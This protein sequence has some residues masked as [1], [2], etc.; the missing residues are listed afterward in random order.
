[1]KPDNSNLTHRAISG[2]VWVATG[3][4]ATGLLRLLVL[5]LLT[6]LLSPADF[7][8]VGAALIVI[9]FS[10]TFSQ[11]GLG[12]ALVQRPRIEPAHLSTAFVASTLFGLLAAGVAWLL[13]PYLAEFFRMPQLTQ[14]VRVLAVLFP[15]TGL[16][17]VA[18]NLLQR[19]LRFRLL[20]HADV[21][22]YSI[23]YGLVG[24]SLALLGWGVWALVTAHLTHGTL[25]AAILLWHKRPQLHPRPSWAPFADLMHYGAGQSLGRI[26]VFLAN[27]SDNLIVG[28]FLGAA[29]LG[30]YSRAYQLMAVPTALL[31]DVLDRVLFPTMSR[32]QDEPRRLASAYLQATAFVALLTLPT[33]IVAA[34]L[35]PELVLV[36]FGSKWQALVPPFQVLSVGMMFRTSYRMSDSLSRATGNVYRRA[37]RQGLY[38]AL[39]VLGAWLGQFYGVTG[40]ATGVLV[41]LFI[42]F[43]VMAQLG[44]SVGQISWLRF[45]QVQLPA[46]RLTGL[47]TLVALAGTSLARHLGFPPFVV[48]VVAAGAAGGWAGG[49]VA[50]SPLV[51]G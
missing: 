50:R 15:I 39:V 43:L 42:N 7:G 49:G 18:E 41:A 9:V 16:A 47:V 31:G 30:I 6:R 19:E 1:M 51:P 29:S 20:A 26:G 46:F 45:L 21:I 11:L 22:A 37:W 33:G 10:L 28:R 36:A 5:V 35:A 17:T 40:V 14:V 27:Q 8:V 24:V 38:A 4:G 34:V 3:T 32:V 23:G 13:A 2:M 44:L 48:L 12:P 25:R